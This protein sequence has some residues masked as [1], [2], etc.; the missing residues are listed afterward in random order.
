MIYVLWLAECCELI[1][2]LDEANDNDCGHGRNK[3][4]IHKDTSFQ[5]RVN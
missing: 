1:A 3:E 2:K 5:I 4:E